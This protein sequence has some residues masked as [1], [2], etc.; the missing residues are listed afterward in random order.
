MPSSTDTGAPAGEEEE[1][2]HSVAIG[3]LIRATRWRWQWARELRRA[4]A[5]SET[6]KGMNEA[7]ARAMDA[8]GDALSATIR[9]LGWEPPAA[10]QAAPGVKNGDE[11]WGGS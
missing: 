9:E 3:E 4:P 2:D 1:V 10:T 11:V 5:A 7:R 6:E 8:E